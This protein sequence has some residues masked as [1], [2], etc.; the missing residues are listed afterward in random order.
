MYVPGSTLA[1]ILFFE[2]EIR[3]QESAAGRATMRKYRIHYGNPI[4]GRAWDVAD[5]GYITV[6][7]GDE[8]ALIT[9][10]QKNSQEGTGILVQNII[11][12]ETALGG[13]IQY[14]HPRFHTHEDEA[15]KEVE[16]SG[17]MRAPRRVSLRRRA[18]AN[19]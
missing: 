15:P 14:R 1:M 6:S 3:L 9:L 2:N 4:T 7:D 5:E 16:E 13:A 8:P 17:D 10:A 19:D 18:V 11:K 12:I